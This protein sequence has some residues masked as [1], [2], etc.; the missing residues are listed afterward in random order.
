EFGPL[1]S[2]TFDSVSPQGAD[3]YVVQ[4]QNART[5]WSIAPLRPDGK[6][7]GMIF[8]KAI[9]RDDTSSPSPGT[10]A[11][12]RKVID[13]LGNGLPPYDRMMPGLQAATQRQLTGLQAGAKS[14]GALKSLSFKGV[15]PQ[16]WDLYESAHEH[17]RASWSIAPLT[18]GKIESLLITAMHTD[19]PQHPGTEDSLRRYIESLEKGQP[20]YG[21]MTP[22]MADAVR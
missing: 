7:T 12:L 19:A 20:N 10:E 18:G 8:T 1:K 11:A 2:I 6:I 14:L 5:I 13:G 4:F 9:V 17:G 3:V 15:N 21:D 22:G 16:G